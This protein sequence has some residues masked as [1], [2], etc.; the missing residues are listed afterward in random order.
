MASS[1]RNDPGAASP[2]SAIDGP[3][4]GRDRPGDDRTGGGRRTGE[5]TTSRRARP[6]HAA[7]RTLPGRLGRAGWAGVAAV[8]VL[9]AVSVPTATAGLGKVLTIAWVSFVAT[10][11]GAALGARASPGPYG[12]VWGYGLAS[13]AMLMSA[14][15]FLVPPAIRFD[16][17]AGGFGVAVGMIAAYVGHTFRTRM[18]GDRALLDDT[19]MRL[20]THA[21]AAGLAIG[22]VYATLPEVGVLL[23][24]G[25]VSHK[26]PAGYATA[27]RLTRV[28]KPARI[29]LVPAVGVGVPAAVVALVVPPAVPLAGAAVFGFAAGVFL[30][31]AA[32]FLPRCETGSEVA[33]E[34]AATSEDVGGLL[35]RLRVHAAVS[36]GLGAVA[37]LAAWFALPG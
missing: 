37:V 19:V 21:V 2:R 34:A 25:I 7:V 18:S 3:G 6:G 36:T 35:D 8:L 22:V 9:V 23:G 16:P 28:G 32:D 29:L 30:H 10:V 17:D 27:R 15:G 14:A 31:L 11:G 13:G 20:T 33:R 24:L 12:L 26:A 4:D 1:Q 5:R